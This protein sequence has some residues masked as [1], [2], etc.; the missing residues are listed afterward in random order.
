MA[1][2]TPVITTT[3]GALPEAA[4]EAAELVEPGDTEALGK[5]IRKLLRSDTL[6]QEMAE[7]GLEHA[8]EYSWERSAR[9]ATEIFLNAAERR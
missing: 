7:R 6:R 4:G 8:S 3:G 2:G 9:L 5:A 1:C